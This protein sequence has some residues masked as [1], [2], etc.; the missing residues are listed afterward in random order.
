MLMSE[1]AMELLEETSPAFLVN[2]C[3]RS[4]AWA[5]GLAK[6]DGVTFDPE[7]LAV[8]ALLHDLGLVYG[9]EDDKDFEVSGGD[10]ASAF[11]RRHG[12][13][14]PRADLVAEIIRLHVAADIALEDGNEAYLLW[15]A[16]GFDV[17]GHRFADLPAEFIRTTLA[18]HP[19]LDFAHGF[20]CMFAEQARLRPQSRAGDL[21]RGGI[22]GRIEDSPFDDPDG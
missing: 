18:D 8:A 21:V 15:H 20:S 5:V 6:A 14:R 12:W 1:R 3:K 22:V 9:I 13:E 10:R 4:H 19:R 2:H 16:T 17:T 7:L 11:V